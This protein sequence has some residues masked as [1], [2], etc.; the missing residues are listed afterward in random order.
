MLRELCS[1]SRNTQGTVA[2]FNLQME[3]MRSLCSSSTVATLHSGEDMLTS[4]ENREHS[5][6]YQLRRLRERTTRSQHA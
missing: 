4:T 5:T 2:P 3:H 1:H 6:W